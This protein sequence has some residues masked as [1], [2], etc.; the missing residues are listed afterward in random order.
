MKM[1][2]ASADPEVTR[3]LL[4]NGGHC[5]QESY[6]GTQMRMVTKDPIPGGGTYAPHLDYES[7]Y[8]EHWT[9]GKTRG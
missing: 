6:R 2:L 5:E 9:T 3:R 4:T 7:I 1:Q 8:T